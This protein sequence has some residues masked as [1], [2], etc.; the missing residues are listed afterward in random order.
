MVLLKNHGMDDLEKNHYGIWSG[1]RHLGV[2]DCVRVEAWTI[3]CWRVD[4]LLAGYLFLA[5]RLPTCQHQ[6]RQQDALQ[7]S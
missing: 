6:R 3:W 1:L 5:S 4:H 2:Y 7:L